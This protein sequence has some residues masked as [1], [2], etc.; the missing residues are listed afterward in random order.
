MIKVKQKINFRHNQFRERKITEPANPAAA[1]ISVGRTP[2]VSKLMALA[3]RFDGLLR[4]GEVSDQ[5][6]LARLAQVTQ[7]RMTQIMNLLH[8]A[9]DI[10]EQLLHLPQV[11]TG[12]DPVHEKMLRPITAEVSW[13]RQRAAWSQLV[14]K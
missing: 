14:S 13:G 7:P 2:R 3:I 1:A 9:P 8:L 11:T 5:T 12:R 6:E 10:Q 4:S